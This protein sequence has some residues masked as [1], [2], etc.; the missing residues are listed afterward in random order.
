MVPIATEKELEILIT[1]RNRARKEIRESIKDMEALA[2]AAREA[3]KAV[4]AIGAASGSS[5]GIR[6][7]TQ[8]LKDGMKAQTEAVKRG[9][10]DQRRVQMDFNKQL[11][12]QAREAAK[13]QEKAAKDAARQQLAIQKAITNESLAEI[14]AR[15]KRAVGA[16]EA[17]AQQE[18]SALKQ[19]AADQANV[20][21]QTG[22]QRVRQIQDDNSRALQAIQQGSDARIALEEASTRAQLQTT[23]DG[24]RQRV[25]AE[26]D[27]V[28]QRLNAVHGGVA[29]EI[30]ARKSAMQEMFG[31]EQA[32]QRQQ[33]SAIQSLT[34]ARVDEIN[35][36]TD[37]EIAA[38]KDASNQKLGILKAQQDAELAALQGLRKQDQA[39]L[40]ARYTED[41]AALRRHYA[42][43]TDAA[44]GEEARAAAQLQAQRDIDLANNR[45]YY[46]L[47]SEQAR[48]H[49]TEE[50]ARLQAGLDEQMAAR[51]AAGQQAVSIQQSVG[52][53]LIEETRR[54]VQAQTDE[55]R[56]GSQ[57]QLASLRDASR[58]WEQVSESLF[59]AGATLSASVTAPLVLG[60]K[61][62]ISFGSSYED[63]MAGVA[64]TTF[65]AS[66]SIDQNAAAVEHLEQSFIGMSTRL[67]VSREEIA[68]VAEIA[69]Q[70]GITGAENVEK[71]TETII[72][73]AESSNL[74]A[75]EAADGMAR[76][77]NVL[78]L[79]TSEIDHLG[80]TIA[81]LGIT[82]AATESEILNMSFRI[83]GAGKQ[84]G[85]TEAEILALAASLAS[86][87]VRAEMGGSAISRVIKDITKWTALGGAELEALAEVA[88]MSADDFAAAWN[89][90]PGQALVVFLEGLGRLGEEGAAN[91]Q[92]LD[93]VGLDGIRV[94][95]IL[96]R[97]SGNT[98]LVS[99][100]LARS[101]PL[102]AENNELIRISENR[103]NT[104]SAQW[105]M[106]KNQVTAAALV[107][108][109]RMRPALI[110]IIGYI[111]SL[112]ETLSQLAGWFANLPGPILILVAAIA[113]VAASIGPL[114]IALAGVGAV[115]AGIT[116]LAT[117]L[118]IGL[119]ALLLPVLAVAAAIAVVSA[120]VIAA[121]VYWDELSAMFPTL[122][123]AIELYLGALWEVIKVMG[124]LYIEAVIVWLKILAA[125][126][127]VV[128]TAIEY[129]LRF[130]VWL[131]KGLD[132][133]GRFL[134][135]VG[136]AIGTFVIGALGQLADWFMSAV[137]WLDDATG[138]VGD[139]V[140][141]IVGWVVPDWIGT[142]ITTV[143][144]FKETGWAVIKGIFG[145]FASNPLKVRVD[146]AAMEQHRK[147]LVEIASQT[148]VVDRQTREWLELYHANL[149]RLVAEGKPV[150][151]AQK[152]SIRLTDEQIA[153]EQELAAL[154]EGDIFGFFKRIAAELHLLDIMRQ[155]AELVQT[156]GRDA[157][158]DREVKKVNAAA[159][160]IEARSRQI[161]GFLDEAFRSVSLEEL[162]DKINMVMD[163]LT[164]GA[165]DARQAIDYM[166]RAGQPL[167]AVLDAL[168]ERRTQLANDYFQ[169]TLEGDAEA[170]SLLA[171]QINEVDDAIR[172]AAEGAYGFFEA[173][174]NAHTVQQAFD[175]LKGQLDQQM[176]YWDGLKSGAEES[177]EVLGRIR[178]EQGGILTPEQQQQWESLTWLVG[179][180]AGAMENDLEPALV[181]V[182]AAQAEW[183]KELDRINSSD[184]S[185]DEK[186]A[187]ILELSKNFN[188]ALDPAGNL[189]TSITILTDA[190]N[191]LVNAILGLP[192]ENPLPP[193][194]N[195][196][197]NLDTA[198]FDNNMTVTRDEAMDFDNT[199][200]SATADANTEPSKEKYRDLV[201][202]WQD[203]ENMNPM[204]KADADIT[205]VQ[206][207]MLAI[208]IIFD[209]YRKENP[210]TQAQLDDA[211]FL[212]PVAN[213]FKIIDEYRNSHPST[214][215]NIVDNATAVLDG[216][217]YQLGTLTNQQ[218]HIAVSVGYNDPGFTAFGPGDAVPGN[219]SSG[220]PS[221]GA[222]PTQEST[223]SKKYPSAIPLD[224]NPAT[225]PSMQSLQAGASVVP[226]RLVD[227]AQEQTHNAESYVNFVT[228]TVALLGDAAAS[229]G[230]DGVQNART[231]AETGKTAMET[232]VAAWEFL[233]MMGEETIVFSEQH[234]ANVEQINH[235]L[236]KIVALMAQNAESI[237]G[238]Y[239]A[240]AQAF[241]D[242]SKSSAEAFTAGLTLL[243][244]LDDEALVLTEAHHVTL[245]AVN[246]LLYKIVRLMAQNA[247][248]L[249]GPA[250]DA[251]VALAD[252]VGSIASA[253]ESVLS[254]MDA[255]DDRTLATNE[256]LL[257]VDANLA[258]LATLAYIM[259]QHFQAAAHNFTPSEGADQMAVA[260]DGIVTALT[261]VLDLIVQLDAINSRTLQL[262][263]EAEAKVA[264][265]ATQA[266]V[267][268]SAYAK[269][270]EGF[271]DANT[272]GVEPMTTTVEAALTGLTTTLDIIDLVLD[273]NSRIETSLLT[274]LRSVA[275]IAQRS[276]LIAR[277]FALAAEGF[278][279]TNTDGVEPLATNVEQ[280][281]GALQATLD[282]LD[283]MADGSDALEISP[284]RIAINARN[285]SKKARQIADAFREVSDGWGSEVD[286]EIEA[287]AAN[288]ESSTGALG[289]VLG[290]LKDLYDGPVRGLHVDPEKIVRK[291]EQ[292]RD[293][294]LLIAQA[295]REVDWSGTIDPE[296]EALATDVENSTGILI[297]V[298]DLINALVEQATPDEDA[299]KIDVRTQIGLLL[300]ELRVV[301]EEV[302]TAAAEWEGSLDLIDTFA[303]SVDAV[304]TALEAA[305]SLSG[306]GSEVDFSGIQNVIAELIT[307]F[308]SD[309]FQ[310][311]LQLIDDYAPRMRDAGVWLGESTGYGIVDGLW[312]TYD[313]IMDVVDQI[314]SDI[315]ATFE[316]ALDIA[317]PSK[318]MTRHGYDTAIGVKAGIDKA[319]PA[320]ISSI[321]RVAD[322]VK[323]IAQSMPDAVAK[324]VTQMPVNGG[325][326]NPALREGVAGLDGY[327]PPP[328]PAAASPEAVNLARQALAAQD[329]FQYGSPDNPM[330][331][332]LVAGGYAEQLF[333]FATGE[334]VWA[335]KGT[336]TFADDTR[337]REFEEWVKAM[338]EMNYIAQ[339]TLQMTQEWWL[340]TGDFVKTAT[341][342]LNISGYDEETQKRLRAQFPEGQLQP[343]V[344]LRTSQEAYIAAAS[345]KEQQE[346]DREAAMSRQRT[347]REA[348]K[349]SAPGGN[350]GT[351]NVT[352]EAY[353]Q[354]VERL[355]IDRN[356]Q[357]LRSRF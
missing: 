144:A 101:N 336:K 270:A 313:E 21:R 15:T 311:L 165:I 164:A 56:R 326:T 157:Q 19:M 241:A 133:V 13:A 295:M 41:M 117:T 122:T 201:Q 236:Y 234:H 92:F 260:V 45:K 42:E 333:R 31:I 271:E 126:L 306:S 187:A 238:D 289:S 58:E 213:I 208:K 322:N 279:E 251:A 39:N 281:A 357:R 205:A 195:T 55:I 152:E 116:A 75:E 189:T 209:R 16:I 151:E 186:N 192:T 29:A 345:R 280:A 34:K 154:R 343:E 61:A 191:N 210:I 80:N 81:G 263:S 140:Q 300:D 142:T 168:R 249:N 190:V 108:Y 27:G 182:R 244:S 198:D 28:R 3:A 273:R 57:Q 167:V 2:K 32:G 169:A 112:G 215:V 153:K 316:D 352:V 26:H 166:K 159:E 65:D 282:I 62:V 170:A 63:A 307:L 147:D 17:G 204:T 355:Q 258:L 354:K 100:A 240:G 136:G 341:G 82:M 334:N 8:S 99:D 171:Q 285:L 349:P 356:N 180:A 148:K 177:L 286:P 348:N 89:E 46:D 283:A 88:Q 224:M 200:V 318:V 197:V 36:S 203:Y 218:W 18:V 324:E 296:I 14:N 194:I 266:R 94:S 115:M 52:N 301:L 111:R 74:S 284:T 278:E 143:F 292:L 139:F 155:Q 303:T 179:R 173:T 247:E 123:K 5:N 314:A 124:M 297:N 261:S 243:T 129:T 22:E 72:R 11:D 229:M 257:R 23:L 344:P 30:A 90:D 107:L 69:G 109:D 127:Y 254:L 114:M 83:A 135:M 346:I 308:D 79:P 231:F 97:M 335:G 211:P 217:T 252:G 309:F 202:H 338:R 350:T 237:N 121:I 9:L 104:L 259:T 85:F 265:L 49:H 221:T 302:R 51:R 233:R 33:I 156:Q 245:E 227:Q 76:L 275:A 161:R 185:M 103:F 328:A 128:A 64:K 130:I 287:L 178:E 242:G 120:A 330:N 332:D 67:P 150:L 253:Y 37:A 214:T 137:R 319:A 220:A 141:A 50:A 20:F 277:T 299:P 1:A 269:A 158:L 323:S 216:I 327:T 78:V 110:E 84:A 321:T 223:R 276:V 131:V 38:L 312:N 347:E 267:I 298:I 7:Q 77:A 118:G 12:Q 95:D 304:F 163:A 293:F 317:S 320:V 339:D 6:Q 47:L 145:F 235:L 337:T 54:T 43:K 96:L 184:M 183:I 113:G 71:F 4:G 305:M 40:Q 291:V 149:N 222:G 193:E 290:F 294:A 225:L 73:M 35:R 24:I 206:G 119:S 342:L 60:T 59:M 230:E 87:G 250:L 175:T 239:L 91:L 98:Q 340:A 25:E 268:A 53:S 274:I 138:A 188:G 232:L 68:R 146:D 248:S 329:A 310:K 102:W 315:E 199:V 288:V 351:V 207:R 228:E 181:N 48:S 162:P 172:R 264:A 256:R 262:T 86:M 212:G 246:H 353:N 106:T 10:E 160:A 134:A 93:D 174:A 196:K 125:T 66:M 325:L 105:E 70:L 255:L 176:Q 331:G 44:V 219:I 272:D 132:D 226:Q